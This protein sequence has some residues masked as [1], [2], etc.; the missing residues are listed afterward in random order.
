MTDLRPYQVEG[1]AFLARTGRALLADEPGLGKTAQAIRA[2]DEVGAYRVL[3]I[4]PASVVENWRRE[5]DRWQQVERP[6]A[7][8]GRVT[9]GSGSTVNFTSYDKATR[10]IDWWLVPTYDAIILDEAHYLKNRTAKRTKAILGP[11]CDGKGGLVERAKHVFL[12]TGTPAPNDPSE[13]WPMLRAVMPG[14]ITNGGALGAAGYPNGYDMTGKAAKPLAY[15]PFVQRYCRTQEN[16]F[17]IKIVGGK[18]LP[19][20]KARIAPYV[21]RRKK[22]EVAKDLPPISFGTLPLDAGSALAAIRKM[23]ATPEGQQIAKALEKG[24]DALQALGPHVASYRRIVGMAKVAPVVEWVKDWFDAG[25]GKLVIF[26]HHRDVITALCEGFGACMVLTGSTSAEGRQEAVDCFQNDPR[27]KLFIGQI[28]AAGTGITLTAASD[29]LFVESS[30]VPSDNE[31]ASMRIHRIGQKNACLVRFAT[32]A[33]SLD[34]RIQAACM[35]K[36]ADISKL[37]G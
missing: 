19:E 33:G 30:W 23:E 12:L 20:L 27:Y 37:F 25:G 15:W 1:A 29:A 35:R 28:Q 11:K 4:S 21:L 7:A 32:L 34:E 26:A 13:L 18:N 8:A 31:Q 2:C 24:V 14:A 3:V 16:G 9:G 10:N 36:A 6:L 22:S 17:G 5:F